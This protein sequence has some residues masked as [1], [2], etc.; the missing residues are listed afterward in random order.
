[1]LFSNLANKAK[2]VA[3]DEYLVDFLVNNTF[4]LT[5]RRGHPT[6]IESVDMVA[7]NGDARYEL[8]ARVKVPLGS[9][10]HAGVLADKVAAGDV[11]YD[12][13]EHDGRFL[14][15]MSVRANGDEIQFESW[16]TGEAI[17][18]DKR[19]AI[20]AEVLGVFQEEAPNIM[21]T[22]LE[23]LRDLPSVVAETADYFEQSL[24]TA[25][26][27]LQ[28]EQRENGDDV[29][30]VNT[31]TAFSRAF[32]WATSPLY[33][34]TVARYAEKH[35]AAWLLER[36]LDAEC[37]LLEDDVRYLRDSDPTLA[38]QLE[39]VVDRYSTLSG[40]AS[41]LAQRAETCYG[42]ELKFIRKLGL[43]PK[44]DEGLVKRIKS[45]ISQHS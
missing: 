22:R 8:P 29:N 35:I 6:M 20:Q 37:S 24:V 25:N 21:G 33:Q 42:Q 7:K 30:N 2:V 1:M 45:S 31:S 39:P 36:S 16:Y 17:P 40:K 12:Y 27:E 38:S 9:L 4:W 10:R 3:L 28:G 19:E 43:Q 44:A 15:R 26:A 13:E 23:Y 11:S 18:A 5:L 41:I 32:I 14:F 34:L